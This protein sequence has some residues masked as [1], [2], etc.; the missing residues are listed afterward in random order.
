MKNTSK[1]LVALLCFLLA[2][3]GAMPVMAN[4]PAKEPRAATTTTTAT[5]TESEAAAEPTLTSA[6]IADGVSVT[7]ANCS[8]KYSGY[9]IERCPASGGSWVPVCTMNYSG[10]RTMRWDD[11]NVK[12]NNSYNYRCRGFYNSGG[13]KRY[14]NYSRVSKVSY[15][16]RPTT[17]GNV[18]ASR[19]QGSSIKVSWNAQRGMGGYEVYCR[20]GSNGKY[21]KVASVSSN[22]T[23]C[24]IRN[25]KS[26]TPY[27]FY[28]VAYRVSNGKKIY[29]HNST[30]YKCN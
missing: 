4:T 30:A 22:A 11:K 29:S 9:V 6:E 15:Y 23:S 28:V 25:M 3:A 20:A 7:L 27:Y 18:K 19:N 12:A 1:R 17:V 14:S 16:G 10:S 5:S 21:N 8:S 2:I 13:S 26:G 24:V